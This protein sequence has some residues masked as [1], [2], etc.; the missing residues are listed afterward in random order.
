M[1]AR[2]QEF[3]IVMEIAQGAQVHADAVADG[4]VRDLQ[5]NAVERWAGEVRALI[6]AAPR[7]IREIVAR[8]D[9]P[10]S[11]ELREVEA[12]IAELQRRLKELKAGE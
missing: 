6:A 11:N 3:S 10:R 1:A 5:S 7:D 9:D 2:R 8:P 4:L 12:Q